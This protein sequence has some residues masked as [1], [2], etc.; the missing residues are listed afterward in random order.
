MLSCM[1]FVMT[2]SSCSSDDESSSSS[3]SSLVGTWVNTN[4][5]NDVL[6]IGSNG[7]W[8]AVVNKNS[9][10]EQIRKGTYTYDASSRTIIVSIQA[11]PNGNSAY[12]M[13]IFVQSLSS[14]TLSMISDSF[15][16]KV[17]KK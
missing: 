12:T 16:S 14:S 13:T 15:G 5:P 17:Y 6:T 10:W 7:S 1:M 8:Y 9:K 11:I 3:S 4:D 2:F